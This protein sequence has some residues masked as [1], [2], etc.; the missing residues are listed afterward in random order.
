MLA[1]LFH[2]P[3]DGFR[4]GAFPALKLNLDA[5]WAG[6]AGALEHGEQFPEIYVALAQRREIPLAPAAYFVLEMAMGDQWQRVGQVDLHRDA[7]EVL[8]VGRVVVD[9]NR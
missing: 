9:P 4:R 6:I 3:V 7:A 8:A 2:R 1:R 5:E